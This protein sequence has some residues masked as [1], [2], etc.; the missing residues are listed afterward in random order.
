MAGL[1][2]QLASAAED[3]ATTRAEWAHARHDVAAAPL[4]SLTAVP[5]ADAVAA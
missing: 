5:A 4:R 2:A 3:P 1:A